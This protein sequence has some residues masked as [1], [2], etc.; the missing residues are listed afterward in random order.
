MIL[1][2]LSAQNALSPYPARSIADLE[3]DDRV[4][5]ADFEITNRYQGFSKELVRIS[6]LGLGVYGFLIKEGKAIPAT[7]VQKVVAMCGAVAFALCAAC[8]LMHGVMSKPM[9]WP[10]TC[11]IAIFRETRGRPVG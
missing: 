1:R 3:L 11:H 5:K 10:P 6:L 2:R 7:E 8:A 4:Y 9:P